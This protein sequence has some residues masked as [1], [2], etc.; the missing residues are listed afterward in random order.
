MRYSHYLTALQRIFGVVLVLFISGQLWFFPFAREILFVGFGVYIICLFFFPL[1]WLVVVPAAL[2]ILYLGPWSGRIYFDEFDLLIIATI[3]PV[4]IRGTYLHVTHSHFGRTGRI[5]LATY[6]IVLLA[7]V[8]RGLFPLDEFDFNS[9]ANYYSELNSLRV[10]KGILWALLLI[11][12]WNA[13]VDHDSQHATKLWAVGTSTGALGLGVVVLWERNVLHGI[14]FLR[15]VGQVLNSLGDFSTQYRIT[16]LFADMH[17][18]GTAIDGYLILVVSFSVYLLVDTNNRMIRFFA[19]LGLI[20]ILYALAVTFSRGLYLGVASTLIALAAIFMS[21]E[22]RRRRFSIGGTLTGSVVMLFLCALIFNLG[23]IPAVLGVLFIFVGGY[24]LAF[25]RGHWSPA[26]MVGYA[27]IGILLAA[28]ITGR[29]IASTSIM[30]LDAFVIMVVATLAS[31]TA[32]FLGAFIS[33]R[34]ENSN[35]KKQRAGI[36]FVISTLIVVFVPSTL[37]YRMVTRFSDVGEDLQH[38]IQH[39][40][41][42]ISIMDKNWTTKLIGQ[43][44]GKFP[45]TYYFRKQ[46]MQAVGGFVFKSENKNTFVRYVGAKDARVGQRVHLKPDTNYSLSLDVR[47]NAP[48]SVLRIRMCHRHIIY[49]TDANPTCKTLSKSIKATKGRWKTIRFQFNSGSVGSFEKY[50]RAPAVFMLSNWAKAVIDIDNI[51]L[52]SESGEE[53]LRNGGFEKG[54]DRWFAYY[55]SNHLPWHIK[56]IWVHIYFECGILGVG[57]F[58]VLIVHVLMLSF[59]YAVSGIPFAAAIFVA[60]I[61]FIAV[62]TFGTLLDAPRVAFLFYFL[63]LTGLTNGWVGKEKNIA[64][65][66][67]K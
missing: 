11:P 14:F 26:S 37:S 13:A 29:S 10:G 61:G 4:L 23:D 67:E 48:R 27:M 32:L 58:I 21:K 50:L 2:P 52:V 6:C 46:N 33:L 59:R 66:R 7:S 65:T 42:A 41:D 43:G 34:L 12:L 28:V 63:I 19:A 3:V 22:R 39:W 35:T 62:G 54:I 17:T 31:L 1:S 9:I 64:L 16:G 40:S 18:G 38:R 49:P 24:L 55:D 15:D 8:V 56:N 45:E 53:L 30:Q 51:L 5:I 47:S 36:L 25:Q 57:T 20:V 44:M 60:L